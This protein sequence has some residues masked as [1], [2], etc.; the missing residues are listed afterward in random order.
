M[1]L[2]WW[3]EWVYSCFVLYPWKKFQ[4]WIRITEWHIGQAD[5]LLWC[6]IVE[7][8][9]HVLFFLVSPCLTIKCEMQLKLSISL[10]N[11]HSFAEAI[12]FGNSKKPD[13]QHLHNVET[14]CEN[15][16]LLL[17]GIIKSI[18]IDNHLGDNREWQH[19]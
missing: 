16:T 8:R 15:K 14:Y 11:R 7:S 13:K 5:H 17:G 9:E 18:I 12:I 10:V 6:E 2:L 4:K 1:G 3:L 19:C